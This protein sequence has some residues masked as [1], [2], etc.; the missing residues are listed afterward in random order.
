MEPQ[1]G[2]QF[3]AIR[4]VMAGRAY[5]VSMCPMRLI[6]RIFLF[7]EEDA[8]LPPE[9]RAQRSLNKARI[10]EIANYVLSNPEGWVFSALTASIDGDVEFQPIAT[11]GE[12]RKLGSLAVSMDARFIIND[13]QHRRAAIE[14]ALR[15]RP[16]LGDETIAIVF[17]HDRGLGRCQQMFADLNR[18]A[19]RPSSSIGILYDHRDE[20]AKLT[21]LVVQKSEFLR[22]LTEK[23]KSSLAP[24]SRKLFTLSALYRATTTLL[25]TTPREHEGREAIA[26]EFWETLAITLP[27]WKG[28]HDRRLTSGEV[29][30]EYVHPHGIALHALGRVGAVLIAANPRSWAKKLAPLGEIDWKRS[31]TRLWEGRAMVNGRLSK[32]SQHVILT[33]NVLKKALNLPLTDDETLY[34]RQKKEARVAS[35]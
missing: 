3:P 34:E 9:M 35:A 5:F 27:E 33:G 23:D 19:V 1:F 16:E 30:D 20:L 26:R 25:S 10:P 18:H 24:R 28:V 8:A 12:A 32:A 7:D 29:R 14:A 4:G 31:N 13:G 21:R 15:E 2:Y 17:F 22:D 11:K 6:P